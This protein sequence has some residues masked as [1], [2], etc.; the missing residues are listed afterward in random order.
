MLLFAVFDD[1]GPAKDWPLRHAHL[2]GGGSIVV[3]GEVRFDKGLIRCDPPD[4]AAAL[5]IQFPVPT[6]DGVLTGHHLITLRTALLPPRAVPYL[7]SLE[8]AR[9]RL[10]EILNK[11]E[12][13]AFFDLPAEDPIMKMV[14]ETRQAFTSALLLQKTGAGSAAGWY[15][16]EA[17]HAARLALAT[18]LQAS[19]ALALRQSQLQH[20]RRISGDMARAAALQPPANALTDFEARASRAAVL[21]SP[22]VLLPE[23]PKVGCAVNPAVFDPA[24]HKI[25]TDAC[26]FINL[27]MRWVDMEP[28]EGKYAFAKTD[29]WIEWAVTKAKLPV[30]A[31]P[32]IELRKAALPDFLY[33][34]EHDYETLRDVVV[35]HCKTLVTRYRRTVASWT[36]ASGLPTGATFSFSYEQIIDLT[37]TCVLLVR[38]LQPAARVVVEIAQP[39]G[40]Y[41][42]GHSSG[43]RTIQPIVYA[44][45]LNQLGLN[46]DALGIRVQMGQNVPGRST[47]DIMATSAMLDRFAA[48]DKPLAITML[49]TPSKPAPSPPPQTNAFPPDPGHWR[50]PWSPNAQADWLR[51]FS[52]MIAGK[53]YIA[54]ICWQELYDMEPGGEMSGGGLASPIGQPKPAAAALADLRTTLRDK[55]PKLIP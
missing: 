30:S 54:S 48:L 7:L 46:I 31:G 43:A 28:I 3:P 50:Q 35:E 25:V 45:L 8:L 53:P 18:G 26:D 33:I 52:A 2:L 32:L 6:T 49:G 24:L 14:D 12:E 15:T 16:R 10:M 27:P 41:M 1:Q 40:E 51:A 36:V 4:G 47:R 34:W 13:W 20:T 44:E 22:G 11:L 29:R 19:E 23:M 17:D 39:W 5:S 38:K 42:A 9:H 21:G 55:R 37:R